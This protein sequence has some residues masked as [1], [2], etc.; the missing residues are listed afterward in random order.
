MATTIPQQ[1]FIALAAVAWADGS[2]RPT[3]AKALVHAATACGLEGADL[4][5]V[6]EATKKSVSLD[7]FSAASLNAWERVLTYA[8]ASWLA[9]LD[10]VI[11]TDENETLARL[12]EALELDKPIRAR[13]SSAAFDIS[14]LPEGG[15]PDKYDFP[16]LEARLREKLPQIA[17]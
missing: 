16:K 10:G 15:R 14:L 1:A 6:E 2:M 3:E 4:A 5:A 9:R 13:A 11:S 17:K 7:G 8:L 12:G